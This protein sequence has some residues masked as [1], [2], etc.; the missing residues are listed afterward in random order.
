MYSFFLKACGQPVDSL[1]LEAG[2]SRGIISTGWRVTQSTPQTRC[3]EAPTFA[4]VYT[5]LSIAIFTAF[6]RAG[7][8][9]IWTLCA[10]F[11]HHLLLP[12]RDKE[13]NKG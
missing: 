5:H 7:T 3:V 13:M 1:C 11:P 2:K 4:H 12:R 6:I 8:S 10:Q 9:D